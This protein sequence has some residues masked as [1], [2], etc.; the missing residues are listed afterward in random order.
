MTVDYVPYVAGLRAFAAV[1]LG[2]PAQRLVL[3]PCLS[4]SPTPLAMRSSDRAVCL[5]LLALLVRLIC[6][7]HSYSGPPC[8]LLPSSSDGPMAHAPG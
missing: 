3:P 8:L 5:A 2:A 1:P 4:P 6:G 7:L